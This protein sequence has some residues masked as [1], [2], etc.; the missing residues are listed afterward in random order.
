LNSQG[1]LVLVPG[2]TLNPDGSIS[3]SISQS[4]V[5][6]IAGQLQTQL[7][8]AYAY[9][10]PYKPALG[11]TVITFKNLATDSTIKIYTIMG[12][13]VKQLHND[14]DVPSLT[15]DVKNSDGDRVAS[16]VYVYQIKN[17]FSEKRGKLVIIR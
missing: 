3:A 6:I 16:G 1:A 7:D 9:P 2:S 8:G 12:E 14:G 15:W 13:L 5:Y 10:V 11:H 17:S 4:A